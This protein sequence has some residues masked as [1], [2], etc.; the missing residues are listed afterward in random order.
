MIEFCDFTCY[1]KLKKGYGVALDNISLTIDDGE[2]VAVVGPSG[3]GKTTLLKCILG[4]ARYTKGSLKI[5]GVEVDKYDKRKNELAYVSQEFVLYPRMTV[6]QNIA[7]PLR[8]SGMSYEQADALVIDIAKKLRLF[9]LLTRKPAQLSGGQQQAVA[10]ARALVKKPSVVLL[11]EPLS[12]LDAIRRVKYLQIISGMLDEYN[13]TVVYVTHDSEEACYVADKIV[14]LDEGEI[15]GVMSD[16]EYAGTLGAEENRIVDA[17][18][19]A[20]DGEEIIDSGMFEGA[21]DEFPDEIEPESDGGK[22]RDE[23]N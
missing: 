22:N 1:Y 2:K 6:Y 13:S 15:K 16:E 23:E 7:Y 17:Q 9:R 14:M 4:I 8:A 20:D 3:S 18:L 21:D 12:N 11:D 5:G 19:L 10:I